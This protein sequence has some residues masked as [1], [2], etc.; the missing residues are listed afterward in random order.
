MI[1]FFLLVVLFV[2]GSFQDFTERD[3]P[4]LQLKYWSDFTVLE[5]WV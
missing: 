1:L 5:L 4:W 3:F 2:L